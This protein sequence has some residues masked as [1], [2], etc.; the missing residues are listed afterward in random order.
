MKRWFSILLL[1]CALALVAGAGFWG[2]RSSA[3]QENP[4]IEA[5]NTVAAATCD[6]QQSVT[7]PGNLVNA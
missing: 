6:V 1:L 7:A 5:P 4:N 2:F 3:A